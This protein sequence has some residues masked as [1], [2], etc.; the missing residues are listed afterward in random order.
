MRRERGWGEKGG[1]EGGEGKGKKEGEWGKGREEESHAFE[2]CQL[3]SSDAG[4][5]AA[6]FL[7][8]LL[9]CS[10]PHQRW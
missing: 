6:D 7:T 5:G 3:E 8:D 4:N 9:N 1:V 10:T 2:F